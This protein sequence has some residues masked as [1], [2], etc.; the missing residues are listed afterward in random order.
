MIL[1]NGL[2]K[3]RSCLTN[4]ISFCHKVTWLVDEGKDVD[5]VY[6]DFCKPLDT[7]THSILL[8]KLAVRGLDGCSLHWVKNWQDSRAQ[9]VVLKLAGHQCCSLGLSI[10]A[11]LMSLSMVWMRGLRASS[12]QF[13]DDTKLDGSI[14][15][16]E[17]RKALQKEL[18]SL[19]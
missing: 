8:G 14:D 6:P 18:Y 4:L 12:V 9:R 10:G 19:D 5:F 1:T 17:C 2:T 11:S 15:P 7:V 16:L 3:D 13:T